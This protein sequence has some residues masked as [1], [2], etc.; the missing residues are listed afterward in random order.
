MFGRHVRLPMDLVWGAATGEEPPTLTDWVSRHHR[1]LHVAY[2][3]VTDQIGRAAAK[4]K[5]LYDRT[6]R[7]APLLPGE[8]VLIR[9]NR[10]QGK[11]K[12]SDRWESQPYVV[13]RQQRLHQPVYTVRPEGKSGPERVLH[14]NLLRPCPNYPKPTAGNPTVPASTQAPLVGWAVVPRDPEVEVR[15][16]DPVS[17]PRRP[18]RETRGRPPERYGDWVSAPPV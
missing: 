8:R 13:E 1:Q 7:E 16:V 12:L 11:G 18:Q 9:D 2:Q 5:R 14:R 3:R 6:A 4:S 15:R 17:P 10:R